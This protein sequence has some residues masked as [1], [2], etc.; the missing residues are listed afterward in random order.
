MSDILTDDEKAF[1]AQCEMDFAD[2]YTEK[3]YDYCLHEQIGMPSP[4]CVEPWYP[5]GEAGG[6]GDRDRGNR[7]YRNRGNHNYRNE[8][9]GDRREDSGHYKRKR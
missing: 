4:P 8:N 1:L 3:D 9:N 7:N 2:R 5:K 6:S